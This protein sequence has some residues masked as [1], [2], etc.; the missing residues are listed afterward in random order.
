[1]DAPKRGATRV[2]WCSVDSERWGWGWGLSPRREGCELQ[3]PGVLGM[4]L[5]PV[6]QVTFFLHAPIPS[7]SPEF[8][9]EVLYEVESWAHGTFRVFRKQE[10][11]I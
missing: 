3:G 2:S 5:V 6:V 8:V 11:L 10:L 4:S 1:M 7:H 9:S